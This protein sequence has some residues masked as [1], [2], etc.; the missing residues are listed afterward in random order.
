MRLITDMMSYSPVNREPGMGQSINQ[1]TSDSLALFGGSPLF[2]DPKPTSNLVRPDPERFFYYLGKDRMQKDESL[3]KELERR[4][5]IIHHVDHCVAV[6]SGFWGLA[7]LIDAVALSHRKEIVLPSL[8]Y[9]RMADIV[10]WVGRIPHFCDIERSTLANS[11]QTVKSCVNEDTALIIGVHPVGSHCDIDGLTQFAEEKGIPLI[12]DSV[13]SVHEIHREKRIGSFGNAE[14]F[15]L[16]ASKLVNGFEGGYI[17]TNNPALANAL[18]LKR[19]G[20]G[21][22]LKLSVPLPEVHGAMAL[23]GLDD[24]PLQ[25]ERNLARFSCYQKELNGIPELR[26]IEQDPATAPSHKNIVIEVLDAWPYSRD[27]TV[28][29]LN[30]ENILARAYYAPPLHHRP[31]RYPHIVDSLPNTDWA[32]NRL[33]SLPCGHLV[34][35]EDIALIAAFLRFIRDRAVAVLAG[36]ASTKDSSSHLNS[37]VKP[38]A[39]SR[40]LDQQSRS[41]PD[42]LRNLFLG[43][44]Q[45]QYYT[46]SGPLVRRLEAE[47]GR[48]LGTNHVVCVSNPSVAWLMLLEAA[49]LGSGRMLIPATASRAPQEAINWIGCPYQQYDISS[50]AVRL[51]QRTDFARYIDGHVAAIIKSI[52]GDSTSGLLKLKT[53]ADEFGVPLFCDASEYFSCPLYERPIGAWFEAEVFSFETDNSVGR[54]GGA[55][56][57]TQDEA[58]ADRLRCMRSSGGI[59]R[60]V[61]VRKTVNGRMS[62][63]QAVYALLMLERR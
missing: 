9:R 27:Q 49:E 53:L 12:F 25:L 35:L 54:A 22:G 30:A 62:E 43:V 16:G 55:C 34:S 5:A 28:Q 29:I 63:A 46:E 48:L 38:S 56:I 31:M 6:N 59:V 39:Q 7:L 26:L 36:I 47:V 37:S 8:T 21:P 10:S 23:S 24:L 60:P 14:L 61:V 18:R 58:L 41:E 20:S 57:C 42:T 15:S 4:L 1:I 13:E 50:F 3:V 32:A 40:T 19:E 33:I 52:P 17:T 45:R 2:N 44:F 51:S 11:A